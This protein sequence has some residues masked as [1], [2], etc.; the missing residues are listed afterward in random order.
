M[1]ELLLPGGARSYLGVEL[2]LELEY[3]GVLIVLDRNDG[4]VWCAVASNFLALR[5]NGDGIW[6]DV[7]DGAGSTAH[8]PF[9]A[10]CVAFFDMG[11]DV[12]SS[13]IPVA[14]ISIVFSINAGMSSGLR[15][16]TSP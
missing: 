6:R 4:I 13:T 11:H 15:D 12:F 2:A 14:N 8:A 7:Y 10:H 16:V 5:G 1:V 9:P 3:L